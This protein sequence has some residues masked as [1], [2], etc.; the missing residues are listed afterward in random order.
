MYKHKKREQLIV[1]GLAVG[2]FTGA[3]LVWLASIALVAAV[4]ALVVKAVF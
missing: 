3:F 4:I 2:V 1:T